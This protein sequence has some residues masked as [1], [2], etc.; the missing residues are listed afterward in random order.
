MNT[1]FLQSYIWHLCVIPMALSASSD[2]FSSFV[3]EVVVEKIGYQ[4]DDWLI[5]CSISLLSSEEIVREALQSR[6]A[7]RSQ[8]VQSTS[9]S[10]NTPP[11]F[12]VTAN[13]SAPLFITRTGPPSAPYTLNSQPPTLVHTDGPPSGSSATYAPP[14]ILPRPAPGSTSRPQ[15]T[16]IL[17]RP[18]VAPGNGLQSL[19]QGMFVYVTPTGLV[20]A[21]P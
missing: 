3:V 16:P 11:L 12:F 9:T 7:Q 18:L 20:I 10:A 8:P 5:D 6:A 14:R 21:I 15:E 17:P 4:K 1:I 13:G 2:M 19:P